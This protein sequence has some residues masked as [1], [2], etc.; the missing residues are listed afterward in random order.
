[1]V[2]P[3]RAV[4]P[5]SDK[6]IVTV[7][8]VLLTIVGQSLGVGLI[9][10][11]HAP[12]A[13]KKSLIGGY[14]HAA[15][16]ATTEATAVRVL[17]EKAGLRGFFLEQLATFSGAA[18]DPRGWSVS[19]AYLALTPYAW[20]KDRPA[21]QNLVVTPLKDAKDLA[22]DH[23][24]IVAAAVA[25]LRG[26]GAYSTLPA[27]LLPETFSFEELLDAYRI[28]LGAPT[29]DAGSFRRRIDELS[30]LEPTGTATDGVTLYRLAPGAMLFDRRI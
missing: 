1:M 18:R 9:E 13:G 10:R 30:L 3:E 17:R 7:D 6:Q 19:V 12:F 8:V 25:R 2:Q 28:A 26:K 21:A 14:V 20:L 4:T 29:L 15:E 24:E 22:F 16:D 23:G 11:G 27:S 5:V